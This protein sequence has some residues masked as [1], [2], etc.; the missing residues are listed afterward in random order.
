MAFRGRVYSEQDKKSSGPQIVVHVGHRTR[1][2]W[3]LQ[4][5]P[6]L[7]SDRT[8]SARLHQ[9]VLHMEFLTRCGPAFLRSYHRAWIESPAGFALGAFDGDGAL[10]GVVLGALDPAAHVAGMLRR[11]GLVLGARLV[12]AAAFRPRLAR[13]LV[14]TR[15]TRYARG[16]W[17]TMLRPIRQ[18]KAVK[19]PVVDQQSRSGEVTHLFVAT[20]HQGSGVGRALLGEVEVLA[21]RT[22]LEDLVLVTPPDQAARA[23]YETLGWS[24][25]GLITSKSGET[26]VRYRYGL[27]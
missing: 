18:A 26:F 13:E 22:A 2:S 14:T 11:H 9:E 10:V 20:S 4:I 12:A 1:V 15:S 17:R 3:T 5:R 21:R 7:A 27:R 6:I 25:E 16:L 23:F 19:A 24:N 8:R